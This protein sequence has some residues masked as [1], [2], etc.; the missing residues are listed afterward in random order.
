MFSI[1]FM[2]GSSNYC[3]KL[4]KTK[5]LF[6]TP[7]FLIYVCIFFHNRLSTLRNHRS[8]LFPLRLLC[9]YFQTLLILAWIKSLYQLSNW[10][11]LDHL[12]SFHF[13]SSIDFFPPYWKEEREKSNIISTLTPD[14]FSVGS[15]M[16]FSQLTFLEPLVT[17]PF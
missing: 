1:L 6:I 3:K 9:T 13:T 11:L 2:V 7:P 16:F 12:V 17:S 5:N 10:C 4:K 14:L 8:L 15:S